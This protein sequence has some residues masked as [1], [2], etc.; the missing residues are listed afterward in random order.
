M[1]HTGLCKAAKPRHSDLWASVRVLPTHT[2]RPRPAHLHF[3]IS[4]QRKD[5]SFL[6]RTRTLQTQL[7]R[8]FSSTLR[9]WGVPGWIGDNN[10][11]NN[12]GSYYTQDNIDYHLA[13]LDCALNTWGIEIDYMGVW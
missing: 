7:A 2:A 3:P 10:N 4:R 13:W 9:R 8:D 1:G 5:E 6:T 12:P 11:T